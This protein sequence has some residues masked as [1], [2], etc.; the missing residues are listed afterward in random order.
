MHLSM[1]SHS[2]PSYLLPLVSNN[3]GFL[4]RY[5]LILVYQ[6]H[7]R[8][9]FRCSLGLKFDLIPLLFLPAQPCF[10]CNSVRHGVDKCNELRHMGMEKIVEKLKKESRC[11][12]CMEKTTHVAKFC[13]DKKKFKCELCGGNHASI[14]CGLPKFLSQQREK[15]N[16]KKDEGR[17]DAWTS[18]EITESGDTEVTV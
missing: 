8:V 11:F 5:S 1:K 7:F 9:K 4:Q 16:E 6:R 18:M 12:G 13:P 2:I 14:L 10:N 17:S 15:A 3:Q